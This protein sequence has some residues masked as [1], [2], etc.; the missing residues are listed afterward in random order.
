MAH[1]AVSSSLQVSHSDSASTPHGQTVL[2]K[3][4]NPAQKREYKVFQID[5][6]TSVDS[7]KELCKAIFDKVGKNIVHFDL[8]FEIGYYEGNTQMSLPR[9]DELK[10]KLCQVAKEGR[11]LWCYGN[12]E[13]EEEGEYD[14]PPVVKRK[15]AVNSVELKAETVDGIANELKKKHG[16]KYTKMQCKLWAEVFVNKKHTSFEEPHLAQFGSSHKTGSKSK[17]RY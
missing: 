10:E 12:K 11:Y 16:D 6:L 17:A 5:V 1:G 14:A 3:V 8:N 9:N 15:K 13:E 7:E 4:F 2:T